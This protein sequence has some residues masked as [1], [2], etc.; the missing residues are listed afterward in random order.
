VELVSAKGLEGGPLAE[1]ELG[2]WC[3]MVRCRGR[4]LVLCKCVGWEMESK[5]WMIGKAQARV[6]QGEVCVCVCCVREKKKLER[7]GDG[8]FIY[9][10]GRRSSRGQVTA[11]T[12]AAAVFEVEEFITYELGRYGAEIGCFGQVLG[13]GW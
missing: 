3:D 2:E 11:L 1:E 4:V 5:S 6:C 7:A 10:C 12:Q 9:W 13:E 8:L